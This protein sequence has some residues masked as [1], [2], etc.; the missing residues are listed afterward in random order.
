MVIM[1]EQSQSMSIK[2]AE[3]KAYQL[4][5]SQDGLYDI[6]IGTYIVLL[7]VTPW[8]DE[9]GLRTPWNVILALSLGL[10]IFFGVILL[11][12]YVVAPRIGQVR[13]GGER[14]R[15]LKQLAIGMG[16]IF[17][18]TVVLFGM[19]VSAIYFREPIFTGFLKWSLPFDIVHTAAGIFIFAIFCVI[20]YVN[21]YVRLYLYGFLFGLG[22]VISTTLQDLTGNPFYWPW[23]L[24]GLV[25]AIIGSVIFIQFLRAYPLPQKS[26]LEVE[27]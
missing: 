6:F 12:K 14:K 11:K 20:G 5:T 8:L 16:V 24:A 15:R 10:L 18:L 17:L 26:F 25:A 27:S 7:S 1:S 3:R 4:S 23:A 21:D 22:Y 13:Y 2:E 9:N 19:T